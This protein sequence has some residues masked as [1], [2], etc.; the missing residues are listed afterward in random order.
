MYYHRFPDGKYYIGLTNQVPEIRWGYNGWGYHKQ[1]VYEAIQKFGWNNIEHVVL[2]TNL[3]P[4]EAQR[5]ETDLII[6]YNSI[7]DGYNESKGGGL[8]GNPW[9]E[10]EYNNVLYSA[11]EL[12]ELSSVEGITAHDITTRINHRGWSVERALTQPKKQKSQKFEYQGEMYTINELFEMRI[13]KELTKGQI[14]TRIMDHQW[15][16]ERAISQ[17]NNVKKQPFGVG[18]CLYEYQGNTYNTW[19]LCQISP[20]AGLK[21]THLTDRLNRRKWSVERA[22]TQPLKKRS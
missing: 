14:K 6:E 20:V 10:F 17:P 18:T 9:C 4:E 7:E 11:E 1:P 2:R 21:P 22:I 12:A 8:G 16:A 13:N 15:S 19:Q 3:S 5:L